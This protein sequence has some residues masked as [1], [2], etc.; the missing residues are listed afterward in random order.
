[1][2]TI[3][4]AVAAIK[5]H[6]AL[7]WGWPLGSDN[8]C[9]L[10]LIVMRACAE[11]RATRPWPPGELTGIADISREDLE[12]RVNSLVGAVVSGDLKIEC[13]EAKNLELMGD[14]VA[15]KAEITYL[16]ERI[17]VLHKTLDHARAVCAAKSRVSQPPAV[18]PAA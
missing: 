2:N 7:G 17:H 18:P 9:N 15:L 8:D 4:N 11:A 16:E 1:M 12:A 3:S 10:T 6:F 5:Q 14:V 13:L